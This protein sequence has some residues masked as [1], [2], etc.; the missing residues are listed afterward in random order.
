[1]ELKNPT[2][3]NAIVLLL[4]TVAIGLLGCTKTSKLGDPKYMPDNWLAIS[5]NAWQVKE[6][7]EV[8]RIVLE[9]LQIKLYVERQGQYYNFFGTYQPD[10]LN[11]I[12]STTAALDEAFLNLRY[13]SKVVLT[14]PS[15]SMRG[16]A[17][18]YNDHDAGIA[19]TNNTNSR[20]YEDD[21]RRFL[22]F[23]RPSTLSPFPVVND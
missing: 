6:L 1:M 2:I 22:L 8:N 5:S 20:S 14:N 19:V 16:L 21:W 17:E 11:Y 15:P 13:S 9:N 7:P 10:T 3:L 18:T 23:D 4:L 12:N